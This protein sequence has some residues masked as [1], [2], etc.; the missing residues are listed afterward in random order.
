MDTYLEELEASLAPLYYEA[1][2]LS[3]E[4][5]LMLKWADTMELCCGAWKSTAW[6]TTWTAWATWF[7]AALAG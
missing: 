4:E 3:P 1:Q 5:A 6:A 7:G 2:F